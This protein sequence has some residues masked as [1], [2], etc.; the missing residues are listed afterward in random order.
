M[1][2]GSDI[3]QV[4]K[5]PGV[6]SLVRSVKN[7][8]STEWVYTGMSGNLRDRVG[9]HL[10]QQSGTYSGNK[11]A[12]S[13]NLERLTHVRWWDCSHIPWPS[14]IEQMEPGNEKV[15]KQAIAGAAEIIIKKR[16]PP[17][18]DDQAKPKGLSPEVAKS[19]EFQHQIEKII[20]GYSELELPS[21]ENLHR[22]IDDM[23]SRLSALE[24]MLEK[25]DSN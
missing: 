21:L 16:H 12:A 11:N 7:Q 25:L 20:E 24:S 1:Y 14:D 2:S 9:Q 8:N 13:I 18:L 3:A 10:T 15:W 23:G 5:K 4:P 17:M 6:Y 19:T 22:K